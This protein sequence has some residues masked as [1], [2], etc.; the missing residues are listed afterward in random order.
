MVS[1]SRSPGFAHRQRWARVPARFAV[2]CLALALGCGGDKRPD[3]ARGV[4]DELARRLQPLPPLAPRFS[5]TPARPRCTPRWWPARTAWKGCEA[6]TGGG[7]SRVNLTDLVA[8]ARR[9][10]EERS[11]PEAMHALALIDLLDERAP[12]TSIQHAISSLRTTATRVGRPA[13]VLADLA[14]AHLIRAER[15]H[16]PR[17]L[18]AAIEAADDALR[19][20]PGN[21][22]ARFD[23]ALAQQR[24]GLVD[25]A[26]A[27]WRAYL[28]AD[29][30]ST[31]AAAA[32]QYLRQALR[33][34][35]PPAP[36]PDAAASVLAAYAAAEPQ[37]A[38]V[39]GWCTVL[40][41]WGNATLAGDAP[42]ARRQLQRAEAVAAALERRR[43]G[44]AT[45]GD[46]VRA[47]RAAAGTPAEARL[48]RAHQ[49]Y[50]A[51]C[52]LDD[53]V[54]FNAAAPRF[55]A[56]AAAA[57]GSPALRGWARLR[58]ASVLFHGGKA[59]EGEK[60]LREI[61]ARAD[62]ARYPA[63]IGQARVLLAA[64]LA[65]E[66]RYVHA[67]KLA[68]GGA[69]LFAA[70]GERENEGAGLDVASLAEFSMRN[71]D[72]A[73]LLAHRALQRLQPY[74]GSYRLHNLLLYN[75][76][77]ASRDGFPRAAVRVQD[78]GVRVAERTRTSAY[79]VEARLARVPLLL[80]IGASTRADLDVEAVERVVGGLPDPMV[81]GWM[82]AQRQ[83]VSA[84]TSLRPTP[85]RAALALDSA[86]A[87]Y[88]TRTRAPL[89]AL[90]PLVD[91]ARARLEAGDTTGGRTRLESALA[92]LEARRD[93]VRMEPRRAG[94]FEA[95]RAVVDQVVAL[96]LAAGDTVKALEYLDRGRA[97]LATV[98]SASAPRGGV[99]GPPGEVAL[100]Y[101][102]VRDTLLAWTVAGS[103]LQLFRTAVDTLRLVETAGRV[104]RR[105][106]E[107]ATEDALRPDLAWLYDLLLRPLEGR[108]GGAGGPVV[109]VADG[110]VASI[111]FAALYD[112]RQGRYLVE[113][114]PL[115][116]AASLR[117]ARR[118]RRGGAAHGP[119]LFVADPA[120]Q[121][122]VYPGFVPLP[123]AAEE[124][125]EIASRYRDARVLRGPE[126]SGA[127]LRD[128]L[129]AAG[130]LHYA[131]HAVF[132]DERPEHSFLLLAPTR[133]RPE[134]QTLQAGEIAELD[135]RHLS[136]V[137]LAACQTVRTG[138]GRAAGFSG[139]AGAFLAAGAGGAVGS[140]WEVDD[141]YTRPLMVAFHEAYRGSGNG[142]AALRDAQ[143]RLL[144]SGDERLRSPSAWA[145][146]RYAGR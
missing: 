16:T 123:E 81:H 99:R 62:T 103:R 3:A 106:E 8:R 77:V 71:P 127:A 118:P 133:G 40:G 138:R 107:G 15:G 111:P 12:A 30:V 84:A 26:A 19:H 46:A 34:R 52:R 4:L 145:G 135:L 120:F 11:D 95:A 39:S 36:A 37:R 119:P 114:H 88:L 83:M 116:F 98:G 91:G 64:L 102:V 38:R 32:R 9:D 42:G 67:L 17:D 22:A 101:A 113:D 57:E 1:V 94:V 13:P 27:E 33:V 85:A 44:D 89:V 90:T 128:A 97:S 47:I 93:S 6:G 141:R 129:G 131:G 112:R 109:V 41:S 43:G 45:L 66:D 125:G 144:R 49:Q 72:E 78:E 74:R 130:M 18:L 82:V 92:L 75:G 31:W 5:I 142:P 76:M 132:D 54:E 104:L 136:L 55:A 117:E 29:S 48:A 61:G 121:R 137:V 56:A 70:A 115:R 69:R 100:E 68:R 10:V 50:A 146:F 24:F 143:L 21:L 126:A 51:G 122:G 28:A 58:Y 23:L 96:E 80:A 73:Y 60:I 87:F 134:L 14:A 59:R 53:R 65:R 139:L 25:G 105:M 63:L 79:V 110:E 108:L 140:L 2:T 20:E 35:E 124:V 7:A 86:A